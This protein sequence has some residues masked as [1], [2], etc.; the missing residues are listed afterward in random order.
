[1]Q[2][3]T[4]KDGTKIAFETSGQGPALI[5]VG[6]S[7]A[8]H[9]FYTPLA[10]ELAEDFTVYNFDR[11]SRGESGDTKPYT[12]EREIEDVNALIA[13]ARES[14]FMYGHSAGS[15]L[16][17]RAAGAGSSIA[18]LVL[19]DPPF[20]PHGEDDEAAKAEHAKQ[21]AH[22]QELNDQGDYK[23]SAKFFLKDYGLS[24][25][26]L[27]AMFQSPAGEGMLA[28]A[29]AL[30]YDYAV[31]GDGLVPTEIAARVEIPTLILAAETMPET[32][33]ALAV[34]IPN[35]RFQAMKASAHE[36]SPADIAEQVTRFFIS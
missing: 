6:G 12:V 19:A 1:M 18:K 8:D 29:R 34:A 27:N 17:L 26:E 7:L 31:L 21:A 20:T 15:A 2:T 28:S 13:H 36:L 23:G 9:Q 35:A 11:R 10:D 25:E 30:P 3:V 14:V 16:A 33:Q 5:I 24:D 32:A 4:S 22:I